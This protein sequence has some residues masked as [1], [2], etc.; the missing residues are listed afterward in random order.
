[1]KDKIVEFFAEHKRDMLMLLEKMVLI[2][3]GTYNKKGIDEVLNLILVTLQD[4]NLHFN[5][6]EQEEYGNH[7]IVSSSAS[8]THDTQILVTG[9]MDTIF[10]ENTN[11]RWFKEDKEYA[12][13]PGVIDMKG[14]LVICI[15]VIKAFDSMGILSKLPLKFIFNS[16]EEIGSPTSR[17]I[18]EHEAHKSAFAFVLE[19]GG[20]KNEIVTG[21][22]GKLGLSLNVRGKA[23][24]A[25]F[26]SKD[27]PSAILELS[28]KIIELEALND[29]EKE[30]SVNVGKIE[31]GIGPNTVPEEAVASIDVRFNKIDDRTHIRKK[32]DEIVKKVS[33]PGT[34][35]EIRQTSERP[36]MEQTPQN[37]KLFSVAKS[38]ADLLGIRVKEEFR[39]GVS[40][41]NIIANQQTPV[42]DGLGAIGDLDHSDREY[43]VKDRL[44]ERAQLFAL[45]IIESWHIYKDGKLF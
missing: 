12:Y 14:G 17:K 40:D 38:Q 3:S 25:A 18:I 26:A 16:D 39:K 2:Q 7:L 6:I 11:F 41:A 33:T 19:C 24:H 30:L 9:H 23:G 43:M 42:I 27:K 10:P 20:L 5:I 35:N 45:S 36:P 21:R 34:W 29:A 22:K 1:M 8:T 28:H 4:S 15:Y 37:K 31:G 44:H 32:I 13:G